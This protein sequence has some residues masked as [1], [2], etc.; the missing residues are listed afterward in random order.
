MQKREMNKL[1]N[2]KVITTIFNDRCL[3][4]MLV[5]TIVCGIAL[6]GL[7]VTMVISYM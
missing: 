6:V 4:A 5:G 7:L 3:V 1:M 2:G